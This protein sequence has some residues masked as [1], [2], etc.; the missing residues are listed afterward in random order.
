VTR[1]P[2]DEE[3]DERVGERLVEGLKLQG[4]RKGRVGYSSISHVISLSRERESSEVDESLIAW[5]RLFC[6]GELAASS[7]TPRVW[8]RARC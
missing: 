7:I 6:R 1:R 2:M 3:I 8:A 5:L 4:L